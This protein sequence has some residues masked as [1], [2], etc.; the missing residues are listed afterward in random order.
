MLKT[1]QSKTHGHKGLNHIYN[2]SVRRKGNVNIQFLSQS[3]L[4]GAGFFG[5]TVGQDQVRWPAVAHLWTRALKQRKTS[6]LRHCF[7]IR[8][9]Q[10]LVKLFG[11]FFYIV[12]WDLV[13]LDDTH[14]SFDPIAHWQITNTHEFCKN[15]YFDMMSGGRR[16][17]EAFFS[18]EL[19]IK[20]KHPC[21]MFSFIFLHICFYSC[22]INHEWHATEIQRADWQEFIIHASWQFFF[23]S[24]SSSSSSS[25]FFFFFFERQPNDSGAVQ[26]WFIILL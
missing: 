18:V 15:Y 5:S 12:M 7:I 8:P 4:V 26:W 23:S 19:I 10:E 24:S 20:F 11:F 1:L 16:D 25:F 2:V 9:S 17:F 14:V 3:S 6:Y 13:R 22:K 21:I